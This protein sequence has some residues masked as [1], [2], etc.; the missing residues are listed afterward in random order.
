MTPHQQGTSKGAPAGARAGFAEHIAAV[1]RLR[2]DFRALPEDAPVRLAKPTSNLFRFREPSSAPSLDVSA[3]SGVISIDPVE[4]L[5]DVGGMTTYEDLVAATLPHGLMPTVVPQ[6]RTITLGGAVTGLGIE[7]SSFRSGLPHEAVQE[8]EILTGSGDVVTATR[9]NEH[10]DLFYGFPNSYGTLGYSLRLRIELEPV[11]AYVNLRHLRFSDSAECMDALARICADAEHDGQPVDF[12]DGVAFGPDELY[13][14]L[15]RFTDQAPWVSDY[16]GND[17]Y[18]KSIPRYSGNGPGDYLTTHDYLWRWDTDWFWCSRAF[19][20]QHPL[21]RPLWPRAL[22]RS[23]VYRK[24]VA[25]DRR[26]DFFRLLTHYRGKRPQEPLIQ[27]IEVGVERGA[28]FLEFFHS[29]IGMTPVWMCPLR[30][31]EPRR[32]GHGGD[33]EHVWPLYPL[34]NDRLYVNFGFWGLVDMLPGQRRA[35]HNRRVE[36]EVAR[37]GGHK[38]LYSDAFYTEEEFW[39]LYNGTAYSGLKRAYDPGGRLLDLYAKCVGNR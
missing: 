31:S 11:S 21:V 30:L 10:S 20:T 16:T 2:R 34:D 27:D 36:E 37:L 18:Y 28:E 6:L 17:V 24:L 26:T 32:P 29:E 38:S 15:A 12:V 39:S 5:A 23:D 1:Q 7:S 13:L 8:M 4:R 35:H 19:G 3:F 22:K 9:D 14:T 25:W 33:G